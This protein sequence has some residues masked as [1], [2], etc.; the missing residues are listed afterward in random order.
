MVVLLLLLGVVLRG[1]HLVNLCCLSCC[2]LRREDLITF[3]VIVIHFANEFMFN[4]ENFVI[5]FANHLACSNGMSL[6]CF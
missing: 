2:I 6:V 4:S 5:S 1:K 3:F